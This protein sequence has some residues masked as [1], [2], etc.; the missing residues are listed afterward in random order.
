MR[1][2]TPGFIPNRLS[3]ARDARR[4]PSMS[5]LARQLGINPSTVSRWE[6]GSAAPDL[7][8]LQR[9]ASELRVRQEF[10][11]AARV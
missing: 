3:E 6:D 2:G 1:V 8:V 4:I 7:D 5:A 10:F 9:L 11:P